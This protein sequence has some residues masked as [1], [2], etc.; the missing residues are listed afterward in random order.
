[1]ASRDLRRHRARSVLVVVLVAVPVLV[2]VVLATFASTTQESAVERIPATLGTSQ[3]LVYAVSGPAEQSIDGESASWSGED[4]PTDDEVR[5]RVERLSGATVTSVTRGT[6]RALVGTRIRMVEILKTDFSARATRGIVDLEAGRLPAAADETVLT[7]ALAKAGHGVGT[8][9]DIGGRTYDVVGVGAVGTV[10]SHPDRRG[11][12]VAADAPLTPRFQIDGDTQLL[13]DRAEPVTWSDVKAWNRE[14]L[15]VTSRQ[16]LESP[17]PASEQYAMDGFGGGVTA[18]I[19]AI[20]VT[21]L[22]IEVVLLAG[23]AFAVSV[24]RQRHELATLAANGGSPADLRRVVLAQALVLGVPAAVGGAVLGVP[25]AWLVTRAANRW[26]DVGVGPFDVSWTAVLVAAPIG[27]VAAV[28]AALR[29]ATQASRTDV[30]GTLAGRAPTALTRRGWPVLGALLVLGG[31]V[32]I[33][34]LGRRDGGETTIAVLTI[35]VVVGAILLIPM[36]LALLARIAGRLPLA[37]RLAVRDADRQRARS[38]PA[39]AAI[40]AS[41]SAVTALAIATSSDS[42]EERERY[43]YDAPVGAVQLTSTTERMP[44]VVAAAEKST[45]ATF[46]PLTTLGTGTSSESDTPVM[47]MRPDPAYPGSSSGVPVAVADAATLRAWG[48]RPTA[49]DLAALAEGKALVADAEMIRSGTVSIQTDY[50]DDDGRQLEVPAVVAD[51]GRGGVP[52]GPDPE[53]AGAVVSPGTARE[54][55]LPTTVESAV[56]DVRVGRIDDMAGLRAAVLKSDPIDGSVSVRRAFAPALG[57]TIIVL[58]LA[59]ALAIAVG[60]FSA[61]A[62]TLS[63]ARPDLATL[64]AVGAAPRTRRL[65]SAAMAY[66]LALVGT[67]LGLVVGFAPGVAATWP[68]TTL[69][70]DDPVVDIPWTHLGLLLVVVPLVSA[71]VVGIL[72]RVRT[73]ADRGAWT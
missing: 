64:T 7:P 68:L 63:D 49:D 23:P 25:A 29:P 58:A 35:V 11:M 6:G 54:L 40:M 55:D 18:A 57:T 46:T 9:F 19:V 69:Y 21:G 24:R 44:D 53:I 15:V 51:L 10:G 22:V 12:A 17:P 31:L 32:G 37:L 13:V 28:V 39:I 5:Q 59:G 14:G 60:T 66:V 72:T 34:R 20:V 61:T 30:A 65:V 8:T 2:S 47:V 71:L 33:Y 3:A 1:M 52:S 27:I 38:T 70:G 26:F 56:A 41:V 48:V 42:A 73:E 62:L 50:L 16:V 43:A 4:E 45:G 36:V 67:A